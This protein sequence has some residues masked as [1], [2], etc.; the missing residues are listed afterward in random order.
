MVLTNSQFVRGLGAGLLTVI[1]STVRQERI[2]RELRGRVTGL[3]IS[4]AWIGMPLGWF[5]AGLSVD[6]I[7]PI[8]TFVA[9]S[10]T[11]LAVTL[12]LF[13]IPALREMDTPA[14]LT[15]GHLTSR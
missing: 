13:A 2:P 8:P 4:T 15:T 12:S 1:F 10:A 5:S 3:L 6:A 14:P 11:Y 7:G 9:V